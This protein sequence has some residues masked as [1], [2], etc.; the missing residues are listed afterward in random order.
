M[1]ALFLLQVDYGARSFRGD[2]LDIATQ[3]P[4]LI[5]TFD[6]VFCSQVCPMA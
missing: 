3:H 6:I 4:S 2:L 5:G 1:H